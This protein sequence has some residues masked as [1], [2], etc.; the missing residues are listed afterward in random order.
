MQDNRTEACSRRTLLAA[1]LLA[2]APA[3][4]L[5]AAPRSGKLSFVVSRN[6]V[7][8]GEHNM[9]FSGDA[10]SPRVVTEVDLLVKLGPVPVFRY[11]HT[12]EERWTDG[13]FA[14]LETRTDANGRA[15][16]VLA[17]RTG[18]GV[19]IETERGKITAPADAA[20][21]THWNTAA[22]GDRL[23]NPQEGK[24]LSISANRGGQEL[25]KAANG[26]AVRATRWSLRGEAEI[27][28]WYDAA[29]AWAALRGK[30]PDGSTMEYRRK[31]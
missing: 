13:R 24:L 29:G 27:D 30:L 4:A 3:H 9:S 18:A 10:A 2:L 1:G 6:G 21:L 5:A 16:R 20:P 23:F 7:T 12:A 31:T 25:V 15:R 14:S 19:L 17:Q 26:A 28:N 8:V 22:F 11:R